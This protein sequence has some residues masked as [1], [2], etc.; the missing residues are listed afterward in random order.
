MIFPSYIISILI[1]WIT[2]PFWVYRVATVTTF[3]GFRGFRLLNVTA[4]APGSNV[5][6]A[7]LKGPNASAGGAGGETMGSNGDFGY[8]W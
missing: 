8:V 6:W 4:S 7:I 2:Q 5:C 1:L 3:R